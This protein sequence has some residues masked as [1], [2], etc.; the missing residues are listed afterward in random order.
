MDGERRLL[1]QLG[2][3]GAQR[4]GHDLVRGSFGVF[5]LEIEIRVPGLDE[6]QGQRAGPAAVVGQDSGGELAA[7]D[8]FFDEK[9]RCQG[10]EALP[11]GAQLAGV[12]HV[13]QSEARSFPGVLHEERIAERVGGVLEVVD[14]H[15]DVRRDR[16]TLRRDE[17][18][19]ADLVARER[20]AA[21]AGA[22]VPSAPAIE[23][24]RRKGSRP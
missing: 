13:G 14:V 20:R 8:R 11:R 23:A 6:H 7:L 3:G 9:R 4:R 12:P 16:E 22:D 15:H 21:H 5:G 2:E 1:D 10:V 17:A 19:G 24:G 18:L